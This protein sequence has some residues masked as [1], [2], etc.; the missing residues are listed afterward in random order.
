MA[1]RWILSPA[2]D[3]TFF[4]GPAVLPALAAFLFPSLR[5]AGAPL[6]LWGWVVCVLLIDVS[7]VYSSLYRTYFDLEEVK[8][9]P[10]LYTLAPL[11]CF[12]AGVG[13][14][15]AGGQELFWRVLAYAA[16]YHFIRQQ[17]GFIAL[18]DYR[19][20]RPDPLDM[21]IDRWTIYAATLG[22]IIY[23]HTH[24]PRSFQWFVPGDFVDLTDLPIWPT[25]TVVVLVIYGV[26]LHRQ[27]RHWIDRR[28]VFTGRIAIVAATS[29]TWWTGIVLFDSDLTFTV[30]NTLAHGIPYIALIWVYGWR[31]WTGAARDGLLHAL[32]KPAALPLFLGV[33]FLIAYC[34][35][36]LWD[37]LVWQEHAGLFGESFLSYAEAS[38]W[39][40]LFVPLLTVPQATHYV[41]DA[42]IWRFDGSN[43]G[44]RQYVYGDRD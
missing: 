16:V 29:F 7:H 23:W 28:Q 11:L 19:Q 41:L 20:G 13:L 17:Y 44:L 33:L 12:L 36:A 25:T 21:R 42:Y 3:L 24:M 14:F 38:R 9:R 35:E 37:W 31:R 4:V 5:E 39:L 8:R 22:P 34:E 32:A 6:P 43:P 27:V 10:L 2:F 18:Y 40:W 26:F 1:N 15:L 30:T